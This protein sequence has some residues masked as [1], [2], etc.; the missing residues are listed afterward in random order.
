MQQVGFSIDDTCRADLFA[1]V[2]AKAA[3]GALDAALPYFDTVIGRIVVAAQITK[4]KLHLRLDVPAVLQS[5][6]TAVFSA[7]RHACIIKVTGDLVAV[8]IVNSKIIV[9]IA[10]FK[11]DIQIMPFAADLGSIETDSFIAVIAAAA[12]VTAAAVSI[13]ERRAL[14]TF[15]LSSVFSQLVIAQLISLIFIFKTKFATAADFT[16]MHAEPSTLCS[17]P[18]WRSSPMRCK[19][20][21]FS[22]RQVW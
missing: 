13:A 2:E 20:L 18:L 14:I 11:D 12:A 10:D 6:F 1:D 5:V 21:S 16:D 4:R 19:S 17:F 3:N 7:Q 8:G 15:Y 9:H 22:V